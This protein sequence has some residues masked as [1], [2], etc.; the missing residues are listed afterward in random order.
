MTCV[1]V[2]RPVPVVLPVAADW[3]VEIFSLIFFGINHVVICALIS[4]EAKVN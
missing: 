1:L 3:P 2:Q 4:D